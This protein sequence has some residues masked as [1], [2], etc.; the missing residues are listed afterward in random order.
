MVLSFI[1]L[2]SDAIINRSIFFLFLIFMKTLSRFF[3]LLFE[4]METQLYIFVVISCSLL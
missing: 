3:I 4:E 2:S 1:I